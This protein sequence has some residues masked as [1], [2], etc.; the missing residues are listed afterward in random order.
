MLYFFDPATKAPLVSFKIP[1]TGTFTIGLFE[2]ESPGTLSQPGL[3]Q[4]TVTSAFFGGGIAHSAMPF[5][6]DHFHDPALVRDTTVGLSRRFLTFRIDRLRSNTLYAHY[7]GSTNVAMVQLEPAGQIKSSIVRMA[8][9]MVRA[10]C[11]Y[12][13]GTA[14]NTPGKSD[15]NPGGGKTAAAQIRDASINQTTTDEKAAIGFRMAYQNPVGGYNTCAG[16][17]S[18]CMQPTDPKAL[19]A[20]LT[21]V[22]DYLT[23]NGT[24]LAAINTAKRQADLPK[25]PNGLYPRKYWFQS[26]S[27]VVWGEPCDGVQH[28]DCVGLI[29]YCYAYHWKTDTP[30]G[31]DIMMWASV[32]RVSDGKG[33]WK[34]SDPQNPSFNTGHG[35]GSVITDPHDLMDGDVIVKSK[36]EHI[37]MIYMDGNNAKIVQA[38]DTQDGLTD[39]ADYVPANWKQRIRVPEIYLTSQRDSLPSQSAR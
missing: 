22:N 9:S 23:R 34:L 2:G 17:S 18:K 14:G 36:L 21:G 20:Y 38:E 1:K 33:G 11:H 27:G 30:F 8:R 3:G 28:F 6:S 26:L 39:T 10:K 25:G 37:A 12:L 13:W 35:F 15:G 29:N 4:V 32:D 24:T 31:L 16:R 5:P 7:Y 19:G